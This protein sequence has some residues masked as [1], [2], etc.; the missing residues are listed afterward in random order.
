[1]GN[2]HTQELPRAESRL[3]RNSE[4]DR[5]ATEPNMTSAFFMPDITLEGHKQGTAQDL[6]LPA[7]SKEARRVLDGICKHNSVNC[8]ICVRI[9]A[10]GG[11]TSDRH[12][13]ASTTVPAPNNNNVTTTAPK[14][15]ITPSDL[16]RGK[17]TVSADKPIPVSDRL[18]SLHHQPPQEDPTVRPSMPPGEAL[19]VLI[20]ETQDEIEHQQMELRRLNDAYFALDKALGMRE[21]RRAMADIQRAQAELEARSAHLYRLHDVLEGQKAAGQLME[22]GGVVDVTVLSGG[23]LGGVEVVGGSE[24]G[25]G[26]AEW[27]GFD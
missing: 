22:E 11:S 10:H 25:G 19:A 5:D 23:L 16:R 21:R 17:K 27:N 26:G 8:N 13:S 15:L 6:P 14:L 9:A 18:P 3:R 12:A 20:K 2:T 1:M 4:A 24:A 7:L